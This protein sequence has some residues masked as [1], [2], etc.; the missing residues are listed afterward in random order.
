MFN[1]IGIVGVGLIGA[2]M[3][4]EIKNKHLAQTVIGFDKNQQS[5]DIAVKN[6]II[7]GY[8]N[9]KDIGVCDFVIVATPVA[10][11]A[12]VI[13]EITPNLKEGTLI[14]DVGSVKSSIIDS[15]LPFLD[16]AIHYVPIHP[17]A[18]IEKFGVDAA[19]KDLFKG[20][21]CIITPFEGINRFAQN[22]VEN[23]IENLGM[24]VEIMDAKSHDN[25]FAYIS[26]LP[27]FIAY[28]LVGL[29]ENK[30]DD[31]FKFIGGGFRD[32]TRIAASSEEMWSD[33]FLLNKKEL[34]HSVDEFKIQI[35]KIRESIETENI[36]SLK[37]YL[38][39]A[40][41]FKE[42]LDEKR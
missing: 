24:R 30:N 33:I 27:H 12:D 18:G 1:N 39:Q 35:D 23:F 20:A 22:K 2:S 10:S 16:D 6:G 8:S 17:I 41:I 34:L 26:H 32:F 19:K 9:I 13:K 7:D 42:S 15:V 40:R 28:A 14:I 21:Y 4:I 31:R 3:A 36:E 5:L 25:V 38:R 11:I 29:I 37:E